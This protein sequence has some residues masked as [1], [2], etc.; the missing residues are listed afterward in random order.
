MAAYFFN[1][2]QSC[3]LSFGL[4]GKAKKLQQCFE[5]LIVRMLFFFSQL[6]EAGNYSIHTALRDLRPPGQLNLTP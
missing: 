1:L 3:V 6:C 2:L 5:V 4:G